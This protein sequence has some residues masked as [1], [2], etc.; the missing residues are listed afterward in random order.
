MF[1]DIWATTG[2]RFGLFVGL[3][4][5]T[6]LLEGLTLASVVPLVA[7]IGIGGA[8][9][10]AGGPLANLALSIL[11][12]MGLEPSLTAIAGFVLAAMGASAMLFLVQA[13]VGFGLQTG[14]VYL[15]QRRLINRI[16]AA[17]WLFF[18]KQR[19]GNLINA[20][21]TESQRLGGAFYQSGLLLTGIVHG[22]IFLTVAATLSGTITM[23]VLGGGAMLFL[24]TRPLV[25]RA[26][27]IGTGVAEEN[28][29]LQSVLGE[30]TAGAKLLK[31]TATESEAVR[32]LD[33]VILR[34]RSHQFGGIFD[35]Q[36]AKAV[37]DFGAAAMVAIVLVASH[38]WLHVD[39]AVTLVILAI[40]VRLM[41]KL[42]GVQQSLQSLTVLLPALAVMRR[43][44]EEAARETELLD[45]SCLPAPLEHGP[46]AIS[47]RDV[48]VV[49]GKNAAVS[50]VY[51]DIPAGGCVA[52]VGASGAGKSS[53][54]DAILGLVPITGGTITINGC[55]LDKLPLPG[56][57]R[58]I[59]YVS[60][61]TVL[62][63]TSVRNNL[64]W[65]K[66]D[67]DGRALAEAIRVASAG[68][69]IAQL[70]NGLDTV[71]G[72]RGATLSGGERQRLGLARALV[73]SPG[74]LILDEA[75][76]ALDA[77]TEAAVTEALAQL[78]G[79][80]TILMIAHRLSA[81]R[82]ADKIHVLDS[83]QLVESSTWEQ[84]QQD[85]SRVGQLWRLQTGA[86]K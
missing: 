11:G 84:L 41:P 83:G 42:S 46:L 60:Q 36:I 49:H 56:L 32:L 20:V 40:F 79:K 1:A 16:F 58:R 64:L 43:A 34:L 5:V 21:V 18:V 62:Y 73:G 61:D 13:K 77:H 8:E 81:V 55:E 76:S 47:L 19:Q 30:L 86:G 33:G 59:G 50:H 9:D 37:F 6:G 38:T 17:K 10:G 39:A 25:R 45:D 26:Y 35:V 80:I 74:L 75:T 72:D 57:R 12:G 66:P 70:P 4:I 3:M 82:M 15:W 31:A 68:G 53:L 65:G 2:A 51:L 48:T 7:A 54:V 52:L 67:D 14:Y 85:G 22:L 23:A 27:R 24:V 29:N 69:F 28:A 63:N 44:E 78:K 71:I